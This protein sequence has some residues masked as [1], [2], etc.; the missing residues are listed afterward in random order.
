MQLIR[1]LHG[2][3][4]IMKKT[5][6][7]LSIVLF[8]QF[9]GYA[10]AED[11]DLFVAPPSS[12]SDA[13]NVVFVIDNAANFSAN[14]SPANQGT[15]T[16]DG[17]TNT[18]SG[19]V[20]GIE[21]CALYNAISG[22]DTS[23]PVNVGIMMYN[24]NNMRN[25]VITG[26]TYSSGTQCGGTVG[27]CLVV[28][29]IDLSVTNNKIA[30]LAW[31]KNW[32][33]TG[34][35]SANFVKANS[36]ATGAAMQE[37]WA[38]LLGKVGLS[39][40]NYSSI[41]PVSGCAKNYVVFVGNSY[42]NSGSPGDATGNSGPKN[43]L[44]GTNSTA[45]KN[46]NPAASSA[47]RSAI[48]T[49][50]STAYKT[51]SSSTLTCTGPG[52]STSF[53]FPSSAHENKGYYADE[54]ARYMYNQ[55]SIV[56]YTIGILSPSCKQDYSALLDSMSSTDAGNGK[57]FPTQNYAEL[58][59]AFNT[60]LS[61][62]QGVNSVFASVSLPVSV[63]TQGL[64]VNQVFIGMFR[65]AP[66]ATPRWMGNL[67]QYKLALVSNQL[68]LVDADEN[69]AISSAGTGFIS[70]CARSYWTPNTEDAYWQ[71]Y[72]WATKISERQNCSTTDAESN[73]ADGNIVEKGA[74]GYMLRAATV[75]SRNL[76]T[77][78]TSCDNAT[79]SA[80]LTSFDSSNPAITKT[81]LGNGAMADVER[82]NLINWLR[83]ANNFGD[84]FG[85]STATRPS[86][87]GDVVHS[88]PV[89]LN[90]SNSDNTPDVVVF[91]GGND[92]VLR[93]VNGN[94]TNTMTNASTST[95]YSAGQELWGFIPQEFLSSIAR[96]RNNSVIIDYDEITKSNPKPY[97]MDG[98]M[99]AFTNST[100]K[101]LI[102]TMRRGGRM[103]Y[104]FD[105]TDRY[106]PVLK[107]R[108]GCTSLT[109]DTGCT[110][111]FSGFG[112][113]WGSASISNYY[114]DAA[115]TVSKM[116]MIPGGYDSCEDF[117]AATN[118]G[119]NHNCTND[120]TKKGAG[121][122][123]INPITG[124]YITKLATDRSVVGDILIVPP[125]SGSVPS[126]AYATDLGGNVYRITIT[127]STG[128]ASSF[129]ITKIA[130]LGCDT[131]SSCSASSANRK[132]TY[133][134]DAVYK[135]GVFYLLVGSGDREKPTA[136]YIAS[137]SIT[138]YF[139]M[140]KDNPSDATFLTSENTNCGGNFICLNSLV[141]ITSSDN[142]TSSDIAAK[143]GWALQLA[144]KEQVVTSAVTV[145]NTVTFS[146]SQI[147]NS[148]I[149]AVNLGDARVYNINY[150]NA[151]SENG[152]SQR[153]QDIVGDGLPPSPVAGMVQLDNGLIV[154]FLIGGSPDSALESKV[155]TGSS[156]VVRPKGRS[157]WYIQ[158]R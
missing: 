121:I 27:G 15:C 134:P 143:K 26:A 13:P 116:A 76:K 2:K 91:Y 125:S 147:K 23:K 4:K 46:A 78:I 72:P 1:D 17:A 73:F 139:F 74:Q 154:P 60:I 55:H 130:S 144:A 58:Y 119:K 18:L 35:S 30:L 97:G 51:S 32:T 61:E 24:A 102:A 138:N 66:D 11:I 9:A 107:W 6:T 5:I 68:K 151:A 48:T 108:Q 8:C 38:Y 62:I 92:G 110:S 7:T 124:A 82:T 129:G 98:P 28:P 29:L 99:T 93:A 79:E 101:Y 86:A 146:T 37:A 65:P 120:G 114:S 94:R 140:I 149:C 14:A 131:P 41:M 77:C 31:I 158:K 126:Y 64:F 44:D 117:D 56:T 113:S 71:E 67:K 16:L 156:A 42:N 152:T 3:Q 39:G 53:T 21:Q 69:S 22:L 142:P 83:G 50:W 12:S 89:A 150:T 59:I 84:E 63:N 103:M 132:F 80:R 136:T 100:S 45:G 57:F 133:G 54:W 43:A 19:T 88:R 52:G 10:L 123:I 25:V 115:N 111:N 106:D 112:Q 85:A 40:R 109:S 137:N 127:S 47:E 95:T 36:Q 33:T 148:D 96:I 135:N 34:G 122:Y 141:P 20:G 105:V 49:T 153:F 155:P 128:S 145:F 81:L 75:G 90:Y 118:G 70:Q 157:Y 104:G 87:H